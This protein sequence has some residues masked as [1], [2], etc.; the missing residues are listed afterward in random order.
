METGWI[1]V[2]ADTAASIACTKNKT[3][4]SLRNGYGFLDLD[5]F[6]DRLENG[7]IKII[8]FQN[9][10]AALVELVHAKDGL[11]LNILTVSGTIETCGRA[12]EWLESAAKELK[13]ENIISIG[14][15]GW[16]NLM[17]KKGY[18]T[19]PKLLMRKRLNDQ[20]TKG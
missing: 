10:T 9:R 19:E 13:V 8:A 6:V 15:P 20:T 5:A 14:H 1:W 11:T 2:D 16:K 17:E 7:S 3:T 4:E 18:Y 12:I